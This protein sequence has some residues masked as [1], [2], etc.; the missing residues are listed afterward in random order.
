M[1]RYR[2]V[3]VAVLWALSGLGATAN[4]EEPGPAEVPAPTLELKLDPGLKL[5]QAGYGQPVYIAEPPPSSGA[6]YI[7][8]GSILLGVGV[9]NLITAPICT[10]DD[11]IGDPDTQD[12]CLYASLIV[13][14]A[15]V[16]VGTPLLV[17]GIRKR[18]AYKE[19]R[20]RHPVMAAL[21]QIRL[22]VGKRGSGLFW[23]V[24]F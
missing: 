1:R 6:G 9:L 7:I 17:V 23:R 20:M 16:A 21:T 3:A 18:R 22:R 19:W 12:A 13:G 24:E 5:A 2:T 14:G 10:V 11:V 15:F 8:A 4:A